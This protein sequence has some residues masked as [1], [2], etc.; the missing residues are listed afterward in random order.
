MLTQSRKGSKPKPV[1]PLAGKLRLRIIEAK[2]LIAADSN[3]IY[4]SFA[5]EFISTGLSD[6]YCWVEH[7]N[8]KLK[9]QTKKKTLNP[10][11][12]ESFE[13]PVFGADRKFKV[14]LWD[15][16]Q[17][18]EDDFLGTISSDIAIR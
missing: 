13:F 3:G 8:E 14:T 2:D 7:G 1:Q 15:W 4:S 5:I 6:P 12:D 17:F 11:W 9:T 10:R 18:G 16:D